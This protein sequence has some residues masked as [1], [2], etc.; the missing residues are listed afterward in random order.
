VPPFAEVVVRVPSGWI[1]KMS[2]LSLIV[3]VYSVSGVTMTFCILIRYGIVPQGIASG[4]AEVVNIIRGD[5]I[6]G[7]D[8]HIAGIALIG[9]CSHDG[10]PIIIKEWGDRR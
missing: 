3:I 7:M 4:T 8:M 5:Y 1:I 6:C 10:A 9:C 2:A